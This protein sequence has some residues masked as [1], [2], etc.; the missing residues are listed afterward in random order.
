V[1]VSSALLP[2]PACA[3]NR[4]SDDVRLLAVLS[5][6]CGDERIWG[7]MHRDGLVSV[8]DAGF[9]IVADLDLFRE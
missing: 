4:S 3:R 9:G 2:E 7:E 6:D 1:F 5:L 8:G